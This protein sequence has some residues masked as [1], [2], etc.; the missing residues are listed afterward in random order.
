MITIIIIPQNKFKLQ[1]T[2]FLAASAISE[3]NN[4]WA[5]YFTETSVI[6]DTNNMAKIKSK[7]DLNWISKLKHPPEI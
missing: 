7:L 5:S 1:T 2:A 6:K 4:S 3:H